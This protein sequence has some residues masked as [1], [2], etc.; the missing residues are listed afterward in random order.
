MNNSFDG[1]E[2]DPS[3]RDEKDRPLIDFVGK[4]LANDVIDMLPSGAYAVAV[5]DRQVAFSIGSQRV[6]VD[7]DNSRT[8]H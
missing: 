4:Q 5:H 2:Y 8:S 1:K 6:Y 3:P 7:R